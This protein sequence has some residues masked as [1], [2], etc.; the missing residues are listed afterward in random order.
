MTAAELGDDHPDVVVFPEGVDRQE[1][2]AA[3]KKLPATMIVGAVDEPRQRS[4][5][6]SHGGEEVMSRGI[7][8]HLGHSRES[9]T[10]R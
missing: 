4:S 1:L 8:L 9:S 7:L 5:Q 10:S 3:G 6:R 2:E